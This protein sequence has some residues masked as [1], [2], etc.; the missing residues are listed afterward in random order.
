[1]QRLVGSIIML[2]LAVNAW[3][4]DFALRPGYEVD[5]NVVF[6]KDEI[7]TK[8]EWKALNLIEYQYK[9]QQ[10]SEVKGYQERW[11]NLRKNKLKFW[12]HSTYVDNEHGALIEATDYSR[13]GRI[14]EIRRYLYLGE[15]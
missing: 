3:G 4:Q 6:Y 15:D 8:D 13:W 1:M 5:C 14:K 11:L 9:D 7:K 10:V 12:Y 2:L